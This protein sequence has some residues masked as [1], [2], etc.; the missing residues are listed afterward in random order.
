MYHYLLTKFIFQALRISMEESRLKQE[1]DSK[2]VATE[3]MET[4]VNQGNL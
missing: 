2:K 4:D 3:S 1:A